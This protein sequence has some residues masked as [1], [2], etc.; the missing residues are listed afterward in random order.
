M[1]NGYRII[2]LHKRYKKATGLLL[3]VSFVLAS[4]VVKNPLVYDQ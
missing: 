1:Q 4:E 3:G 2:A